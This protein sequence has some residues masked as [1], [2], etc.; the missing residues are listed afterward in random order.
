MRLLKARETEMKAVKPRANPLS[1]L[2]EAI[3]AP[4]TFEQLS[5]RF[6]AINGILACQFR[7]LTAVWGYIWCIEWKLILPLAMEW[8]LNSHVRSGEAQGKTG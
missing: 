4:A 5:L 8:A 6:Q 7:P 3:Q 2:N 1:A